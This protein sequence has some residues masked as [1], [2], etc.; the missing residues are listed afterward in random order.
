M[1]YHEGLIKNTEFFTTTELAKK[2][3]MNV[4]VITRKVQSGEINAYKI[5][6]DWRIPEHSVFEWLEKNSNKSGNG[7]GNGNGHQKLVL[8][9]VKEKNSVNITPKAN[10]RKYLLEY[11]LAQFEPG[12]SYSKEETERIINRYN[13]DYTSVLEEFVAEKMLQKSSKGYHRFSGYKLSG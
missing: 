3:K 13:E 12:R 8:E 5:G 1:D 2:L 4:Q 10:N 6:K 7:N 11:I 9:S